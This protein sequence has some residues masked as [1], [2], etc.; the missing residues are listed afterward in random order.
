LIVEVRIFSR[1]PV[2]GL[3]RVVA[4]PDIDEVLFNELTDPGDG[5]CRPTLSKASSRPV[6]SSLR[7]VGS[8]S[9]RAGVATST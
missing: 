2:Q 5:D 1:Q 8:F 7:G 3:E 6:A 4:D 9:P